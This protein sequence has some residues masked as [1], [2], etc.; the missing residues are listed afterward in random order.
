M[1]ACTASSNFNPGILFTI[2]VY[3][4]IC[5]CYDLTSFLS[6]AVIYE[7][8]FSWW[9]G[10]PFSA[11]EPLATLFRSSLAQCCLGR[12]IALS[13]KLSWEYFPVISFFY[14]WRSL[15][16][17]FTV[18]HCG[19]PTCVASYG[20]VTFPPLKSSPAQPLFHRAFGPSWGETLIQDG[21][22]RPLPSTL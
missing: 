10:F 22:L 1:A 19:S 12:W 8:F 3:I 17:F 5:S 9:S 4:Q 2:R 7:S 16:F 21:R 11:N 18:A 13:F 6:S 14:I 20:T 15:S